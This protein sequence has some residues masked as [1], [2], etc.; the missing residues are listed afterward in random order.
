MVLLLMAATAFHGHTQVTLIPA[1]AAW[2]YFDDGMDLGTAWRSIGF[3]DSTWPT[4][5]AQ[6]GYGD[7]DETTVIDFGPNA[8]LKFITYYFRHIF[9]VSNP[10]TITN[11]QAR[12]LRDDGAVLYVNGAEAFR[13][14]M[15]TGEVTSATLATTAVADANE[16][17]FFYHQVSPALLV[18][19]DNLLALEIHQVL[20]NSTDVSFDLELVGNPLP[21]IAITSPTNGQVLQLLNLPISVS[22]SP[23]GESI[24]RVEFFAD[25]ALIG[26][27][28][29]A[30]YTFVWQGVSPG[31]YTLTTRLTDSSGLTATSAPVAITVLEIPAS[32]L[33]NRG[34]IW[35]YENSNTDLGTAWRQPGYNDSSW[36]SGPG[37]LGGGG[38]THLVTT[39][40]IGPDGARYPTVYFRSTFN[41]A[42]PSVYVSLRVNLLRDDGAAVYLNGQEIVRDGIA[43]NAVFTDFAVQTVAD[44]DETTYFP[45][46]ISTAGLVVGENTLAVE[47]KNVGVTSSDLGF[48]LEIVGDL[49][50]IVTLASPTPGQT[51]TAPTLITVSADASDPGGSLTGVQFFDGT[52]G[53]GLVVN[54]PY[55]LVWSNAIDGPHM[56]TA[57]AFD[58]TGN[59]ATSAPVNITIVDPNPPSLVSAT[60][61]SNELSVVFSK[62]ITPESAT[63][64]ANYTITSPTQSV[65]ILGAA[66]QDPGNRVALSTGPMM[67]GQTYTLTVNHIQDLDELFI[68]PNSQIEFFIGQFQLA[69]VGSPVGSGSQIAV[70]GGLDISGSGTN[71][72]GIRD[73]FTFSYTERTDDFDLKVRVSSLVLSHSWAKAGLMARDSL[74]PN[75]RFAASVATPGGAGCFFQSRTITGAAAS[76]QGFFPVNYPYTWLR[77]QRNGDLFVGL[78]S[79]DGQHWKQ[80]GQVTLAGAPRPMTVGLVVA[81]GAFGQTTTAGFRDFAEA[82]GEPIGQIVL[83]REPL[84]PS[85]RRTSLAISEIMYHPAEFAGMTGSLEFIEIYNAQDYVEDLSGFQLD[86][87]VHYTFPP[88]TLLLSGGFLVVARDPAALQSFYGIGGVLG[89]WRLQTN[90]TATTTNVTAENLP[91]NRGTVR[92]EN[93]LG[94]H[95]LEVN[96]DSEGDWPAAADGGGPSL[97]LARPSFG[98][99][100]ARAW[101]ASE[102]VGG[103]PGRQEA[104]IPDPLRAVVINEFLA[105]TD[106]PQTDFIEL[107]NTSSQSVNIGGCWLSDDVRTNKFHIATNIT[108]PPRGF[109]VFYEAQLGFRLSS[110]GEDILLMNPDRTRVL[111]AIRFGG[112]QNGV[113]RG[114]YPDGAPR[115]QELTSPT[116]GGPNAPPL[117]RPVVINEIMYHPISG[118][119]D[120]EYVELYNAGG[121]TVDLSLWSLDDAVSFTFPRNTSL[122]PGGYLV[123]AKNRTNLLARYPTLA[124]N[125]SRVFGDYDGQLA[126]GGEHLALAMPD[127]NLET[128]GTTIITNVF[129][130]VVDEVTYGD[131]GRWGT[132]SDGGGSSLELIDARADNR[133]AANWADSDESQ[134]APWTL[135]QRTGPLQLGMTAANGTPNRFE[136]FIEGPGECLVDEMECRANNGANLIGNPGFESGASTWAFQGTHV[137]SSVQTNGAYAGSRCLHVRAV[138]RGDAGPNRIRTGITTLPTTGTTNVAT[139]RARVRWLRGDTNILLRVRGQWLECAGSMTVP[140]NLGTPG[141]PNSRALSNAPPA[142]YDVVHTPI[143][144]GANEAV[145]VTARLHDPDGVADLTLRYRLDPASS[146]SNVSMRDD[147]SGGDAVAGDGIW[148][149]TIPGRPAG[150]LVAFHLRATDGHPSPASATFPNDAPVRE[151]LVRFG[152]SL[153]QGSIANYRIWMTQSNL[154]YWA[155]REKNSNE[156]L[157]A[158]FVYGDWRVVYN[159]ESLYSASPF[160]TPEYNGPLGSVVCDYEVLFPKDDLFLGVTDYVLNGQ[161]SAY[162]FFQNDLS[163]QAESTAY[164]FGRKLGLGFNHKRHV[165]VF[166]NGQQRGMVYFDHVQP[167]SEVL[168]AY[169][170]NDADGRLHKIE[171][172][173]EFDDAGSGFDYIT[174]FMQ[175]Y[176]V[177]GQKRTERYRFNFRPRA[178]THPND[179]ADLMAVVDAVNSESPEPYTSA[180][181]GLVDMHNWMR[182]W[183][184]QHMLGNWD[185][186]G[187]RRGKNMYAY[188]PTEGP[189][190][191]L[192]WD[193]DLVLGKDSDGTQ[194]N[195]FDTSGEGDGVVA[196]MYQHPPFVREFWCA[197]Q[198]LVDGPMRPENYSYLVDARYQSFQAN[199]VPVDSPAAMKTWIAGRRSYILTQIPS[200]SFSVSGPASF[201]SSSNYL[202]LTGTAPVLVKDILVNGAPYVVS[203]SSVTTWTL[204]MPLVA[205]LNTILIQAAD[206]FGTILGSRTLTLTYTGA[207]A[208]PAGV[209]LFNEI[210][211]NP[212]RDRAGFLELRNTHPSFAFDLSGWRVNGLSYTFSPGAVLAPN[213]FLLLVENRS[214]F[215]KLY[216]GIP[217]VFDQVDGTMDPDGETLTL[218]RPGPQPSEEIVVDK[219]K[220]EARAP[221][222]TPLAGTRTASLQLIDAAQD[223]A[224]V[225]NWSVGSDWKF[226]SF[227]G[228]PNAT[229]LVIYPDSVGAMFIDEMRLER[230][231]VRGAGTNLLVNGDF[232]SPLAPAWQFMGTNGTNSAI[233]TAEKFG[234]NSSL[235]LRFEPNVS[236]L[237]YLYQNIAGIS[238]SEVHTLSFYYLPS[239]SIDNLWFRMSGSTFRNSL[240]VRS[241]DPP[242]RPLSTPSVQ[243]SLVNTLPPYPLLWLNEVLPVNTTGLSDNQGEREPW[244]ELYNSGTTTISLEGFFLS[245]NYLNLTRWSFPAGTTL[246]PGEFRVVFADGETGES[247]ALNWHTSFRVDQPSGSVALSRMVNGSPQIVDYLNFDNLAANHSYGSFPDGQLFDRQEFF[248][249]TPGEPNNGAAAPLTVF[250]NEWMAAN[251]G[252][253]LDPADSDDDD[254]FELY[255]PGPTT[256]DLGGYFLTDDLAAPFKFQVP[257]NGQYV[258]PANGFLL[259]W[260]DGE[261][262]QN[263]SDRADLHVGFNLRQG[264]EAIGLFASDGTAIDT[265]SFQQQTENVS[266]GRFPD[267]TADRFFMTT[268]TPRAPNAIDQPA[269]VN[270]M[271]LQLLPNGHVTFSFAT[272]LGRTYRVEYKN[273]LNNPNWTLLAGP[274]IG[275]GDTVPIEDDTLVQPER[276]YRVVVESGTGARTMRNPRSLQRLPVP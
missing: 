207:D 186:Y 266:E 254:W 25:G 64:T 187:Y 191:M 212:P 221:W 169:F 176:V 110:D 232:E 118:D 209:V 143:L 114:R 203:W 235:Q 146:L 87:D 145:V 135:V 276:F 100:N 124:A 175:N 44:A 172:W 206:R 142:I 166:L 220:Y 71:I 199:S 204:R 269:P 1:G 58:N 105:H 12:L 17:K 95:L 98:E 147:G 171:D 190:R 182:T 22:A 42:D 243:N 66:L 117:F 149:G 106:P 83:D 180:T 215:A 6:L 72:A 222:P 265:I 159:A 129:Y 81:S 151:C 11:L 267:G 225:S 270:I 228:V 37:P 99:R 94:A 88:G 152:E 31:A 217:V 41:V 198:E 126:N 253:V 63:R 80:L 101:A 158:T 155:A 211:F 102:L 233:S 196:R 194:Q 178:R 112:Q 174:A 234:G 134:K 252:F 201:Q 76:G 104:F 8:D 47:V 183:A 90:V 179:F 67:E 164:W 125:P 150:T 130:I 200:A 9:N 250:I 218:L 223:N 248:Y 144:P 131:G 153:R 96:Y 136:F 210:M 167:S 62:R 46:D 173:F 33:V 165:F 127:I 226:Y 219:L 247:T 14:N 111:D 148:S 195:L 107:F 121:N 51:F 53:L 120:D 73:Q 237:D 227:T 162:S 123:V 263:T 84:G 89:P 77:L 268:P 137:R 38:D 61:T 245:D 27:R 257:D 93:E 103:S 122:A 74:L 16:S 69:D 241:S 273:D 19:G 189:W 264:G 240:P 15:P 91:N 157:D 86:G 216:G 255:N 275:T 160:H 272:E 185:S 251:T 23:G 119:S 57:V 13:S 205:G 35:K 138:E 133:L 56:L 274:I 170:P 230:G 82:E 109:A 54:P 202:T 48:D 52:A 55:S 236:A 238:P 28:T 192:L 68:A 50:P 4:G 256:A 78:A 161:N 32:I 258:V 163:A 261:T 249:P 36:A 113:S 188:K 168:D 259:V 140:T 59:A 177:N 197:L 262:G 24:V 184:L 224:R 29:N 79:L 20:A 45:F 40:D 85:S 271:G 108:L 116:D 231:T 213:S 39:F 49:L 10:A 244:I 181:L 5:Q 154:T 229:R 30:P 156:G 141:A 3:S 70:P 43:I 97:V 18:S 239:P 75:A 132:W 115:F 139:L 208:D 214:E 65:A 193:L 34:A 26:Q 128:N 92:L 2:K 21:E 260:A 7:G 60:A 246:A 242:G